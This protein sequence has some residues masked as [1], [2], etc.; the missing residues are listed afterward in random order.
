[1]LR[2]IR[3]ARERGFDG[4]YPSGSGQWRTLRALVSAGFVE[5]TGWGQTE[6]GPEREV[7]IFDLTDAGR[8][9][10]EAPVVAEEK[11]T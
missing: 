8:A 9:A 7:Q 4:F 10:L 11:G 2:S 6:E 5:S 1:M 3:H